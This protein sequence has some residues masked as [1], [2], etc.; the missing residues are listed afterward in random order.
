MRLFEEL[1][2]RLMVRRR[3]AD[4][5]TQLPP[6]RRQRV[7]VELDGATRRTLD[8][9]EREARPSSDAGLI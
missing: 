1:T 8:A 4:V 7:L 6:K 9:L 5:L 3:K 2:A